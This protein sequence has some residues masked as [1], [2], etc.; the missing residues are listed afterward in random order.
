[1]VDGRVEAMLFFLVHMIFTFLDGRSVIGEL[2]LAEDFQSC[3]ASG[4]SPRLNATKIRAKPLNLARQRRTTTS[5][6]RACAFS[7]SSQFACCILRGLS[8]ARPTVV[9]VDPI[10]NPPGC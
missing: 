6:P 10:P 2:R 8:R 4:D 1:M 3:S 9:F 5:S 7:V